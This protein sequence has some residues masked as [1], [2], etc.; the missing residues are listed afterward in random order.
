MAE[1]QKQQLFVELS[2]IIANGEQLA[3]ATG[4]AAI[5]MRR[6]ANKCGFLWASPTRKGDFNLVLQRLNLDPE[7]VATIN[8][9]GKG[10][11]P[12]ITIVYAEPE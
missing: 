11:A 10:R 4:Q 6:F 9:P 12:I 5:F 1:Y 8:L 7:I 2:T 3:E